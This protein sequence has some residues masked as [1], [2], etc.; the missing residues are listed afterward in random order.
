[1]PYRK[2]YLNEPKSHGCVTIEHQSEIAVVQWY[3]LAVG[4]ALTGKQIDVWV[5]S[6]QIGTHVI[7][8]DTPHG[9]HQ[10]TFTVALSDDWE[11][12]TLIIPEV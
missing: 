12:Y 9:F 8:I 1:M 3:D 2:P 4:D 6:N 11:E 5:K 7:T 10:T